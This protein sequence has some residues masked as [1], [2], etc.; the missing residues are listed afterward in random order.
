[1]AVLALGKASRLYKALVY[2]QKVAQDVGA[3]QNSGFLGSRFEIGV[4]ARPGVSLEKLEE[5]IDKEVAKLRTA[6]VTD[7]ELT[8]AKNWTEASFVKR[9][10]SVR[11]RASLLNMYE[12][13]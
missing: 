5:A 11:E 2:E 9:L 7:E 3:S 12:A 8:R 4:L 13:E 1:G 6:P 10:E